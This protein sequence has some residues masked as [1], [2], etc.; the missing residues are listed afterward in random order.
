MRVQSGNQKSNYYQ[1]KFNRF[2]Y[3]FDLP[4][5]L[6]RIGWR[7]FIV[8]TIGLLLTVGAAL[9]TG[10]LEVK[11]R[12]KEFAADCRDI[13]LRMSRRLH[14]Y[15]LLLRSGSAFLYATDSVTRKEWR[16]F[17]EKTRIDKNLAGVQG[18][19]YAVIIPEN[20]LQK[21]YQ[22]LQEDGFKENIVKLVGKRDIYTSIIYLEP[23]KGRNLRAIGYDMFSEPVRRKAM[24]LSRDS[25]QAILSGRVILVQESDK[26]VQFGTLMYVPAYRYGLPANTVEERRKAIQ[27]WVYSPFRMNDLMYG[28][29][30]HWDA[31]LLD[32]IQLQVYDGT[33]SDANLLFDSQAADSLAI[34]KTPFQTFDQS[35]NFNG[36][37]WILHFTQLRENYLSSKVRIILVSGIIISILIMALFLLLFNTISQAR[38]IAGDSTNKLKKSEER[39]K[40]LLNSTAE[41]IYG[42]DM[43]GRCTFSNSSCIRMLGYAT[44]EQ[45]IGENMHELIHHSNADGTP[46]AL[47]DCRIHNSFNTQKGTHVEDEV[48][49]RKDGTC[50][51]CEYWSYPL[52]I[53]GQIEGAVVTFFDITERKQSIEKINNARN[54]AEKANQAKSEFLSRMSHELRT[55]MNSILG[56]AQLLEMGGKLNLQQKKAV[57]HIH[58]SGKHLLNLINEVLEISRIEAGHLELILEPVLL[59]RVI[60]EMLDFVKPLAAAREIKIAVLDATQ[61]SLFVYADRRHLKQV[62]LN[63]LSNAIKYNREGG[64]ISLKSEIFPANKAGVV[65][66]RIAITDTGSGILFSDIP[67]L[68]TPFERIGAEKTTTEGTGLGLAV[69]KKLINAMNGTI[70]VESVPGVGSTFWIKLPQSKGNVKKSEIPEEKIIDELP[71]AG[72]TGTILLIE[73]NPSNIDLIEQIIA[74]HRLNISLI[75]NVNGKQTVPLAIELEPDLILLDLNLPD[76]H[77]YEV[78]LLLQ[79]ELKTREIPVV[80]ISADAT[81][82]QIEN[83]LN[84]GARNYLTKPLDVSAFL[85]EVDKW[86][87]N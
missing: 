24:E 50:F 56:F 12:K 59:Q 73:D 47:D 9:Y 42:L 60:R 49:W 32:R 26:D 41:A 5:V 31:L 20:K 44:E 85:F 37:S 75:T 38:L 40:K 4:K 57:G 84:A 39:F 83:L 6:L 10:N 15:A 14:T 1:M 70:G 80:I 76:I 18:V 33:I 43:N 81:P 36:K 68:F 87:R 17:I 86:I 11:T 54:E 16:E 67:K 13:E 69:V 21:H 58:N 62:L 8:L 52:F 78:I 2:K 82:L 64:T 74:S 77:G 51:P 28:I 71:S 22:Q 79:A 25:D 7:G 61:D 3:S 63:L 27:G 48:L 72:K 34:G 53:N 35:V 46:L 55:P 45:L 19:G 30:G 65:S 29:L 66:V 23:Q